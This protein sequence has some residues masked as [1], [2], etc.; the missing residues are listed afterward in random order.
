MGKKDFSKEDE[1]VQLKSTESLYWKIERVD[2]ELPFQ[3][4]DH[5]ISLWLPLLDWCSLVPLLFLE[6]VSSPDFPMTIREEPAKVMMIFF[7]ETE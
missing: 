6:D 4:H 7:E 1:E 3:Q 5:L 2:V